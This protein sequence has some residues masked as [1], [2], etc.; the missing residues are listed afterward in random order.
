M[1]DAK[2]L[3]LESFGME[4]FRHNVEGHYGQI[5]AGQIFKQHALKEEPNV[6]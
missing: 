4:G 2:C 5:G 3:T 6:T 1:K